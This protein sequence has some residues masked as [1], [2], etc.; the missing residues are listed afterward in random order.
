MPSRVKGITI[1]IGGNT[2]G[3]NKALQGTN[4]EIRATQ[5]NLADVERLLKLDP[6][7]VELVAQ[8]QRMLTEAIDQTSA[9]LETLKKAEKNAQEQVKQG[10][11]SQQQYDSLKREIIATEQ[12]LGKYRKQ[13]DETN[14]K[15]QALA[16]STQSGGKEF[17][18]LAL[19][20]DEAGSAL[21]RTADGL[22]KTAGKLK[23]VSI[24]VAAAGA[25]ITA[26]VE[27]TKELRMDLSKLDQN[28]K[29]NAVSAEIARKAWK[30]FS[31]QSGETDSS[32]EA[33]SNLLQ[34]GFTESNLQKAVEGLAGAAQ[35]FPDT[36]KVESLADSLQETLKTGSATGQFAEVLD[37]LGISSENFS[38]KLAKCKTEAQK[39]DLALQ[40][41]ADAGLNDSYNAWKKNNAAMLEGE[42]ATL[43]IQLKLSELAA[44]IQPLITKVLNA[45]GKLLD[46]FNNLDEGTKNTII[47]VAGFTA[48]MAPVAKITGSAAGGIASVAEK[49]SEFS[50]RIKEAGGVSGAF[51]KA[52]DFLSQHSVAALAVGIGAL[53]AGLVIWAT[54]TRAVSEEIRQTE[55]ATNALTE[56]VRKNAEIA[57]TSYEDKL[58]EIAVTQTM[59]QELSVLAEKEKLSAAEKEKVAT[60]VKE[61]NEQYPTLNL[62]VGK[63]GQLTEK[64]AKALDKYAE[65]LAET[66]KAEA[67]RAYLTEIAKEK[68]KVDQQLASVQQTLNEKTKRRTELLAILNSGIDQNSKE[69]RD[70]AHEA[71][72]L[73][74][75]ITNLDSQVSAL[76]EQS[77]TLGD[78]W[79]TTMSTI[80]GTTKGTTKEVAT[81][82]DEMK[83]SL[84]G[85]FS[86]LQIDASNI[87]DQIRKAITKS[88][89][90]VITLASAGNKLFSGRLKFFA[91]GGTLGNGGTAIVG[92]AGPEILTVSGG[93]ATV[94]PLTNGGSAPVTNTA[95]LTVNLY[96]GQ[97]TARDGER[98]ARDI[99]Y[100]L[101]RAYR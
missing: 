47:R 91:K 45:G 94:T 75:E 77:S 67:G 73:G 98:I 26:A 88:L 62:E 66:A 51:G 49:A 18:Q 16:R 95:N 38:K 80:T 23:N 39:Q 82:A 30:E 83:K 10:K 90:G 99:N 36:L 97:Y 24:G 72:L 92:E 76:T 44:K 100:R 68:L 54:K 37:R 1:E 41:L 89:S 52:L 50:M 20:T 28:A 14:Q 84:E 85:A 19:D 79:D 6:N 7:N 86:G 48:A 22:G 65:K 8:K 81:S 21:S 60:Y 101:G 87:G 31:L 53:A 42:E 35:R 74:G 11:I 17:K 33:V 29:E 43:N 70:A 34:A 9:K 59:A 25:A 78:Q 32:V 58:A 40:T 56:S 2:T 15:Q 61:L 57:R 3:L 27:S 71:Q 12:S 64:S 55:Q 13:L 96:N 46:W 69:Y 63:N 5:S 4:K 93:R